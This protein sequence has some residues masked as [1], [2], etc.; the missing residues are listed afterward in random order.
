LP[1]VDS[2]DSLQRALNAP[3][4]G[5]KPSF[6][7]Q[8]LQAGAITAE[9]LKSL[10]HGHPA[11]QNNHELLKL[12]KT[13]SGGDRGRLDQ[14]YADSLDLPLVRLAQFDIDG[15]ALERVPADFSRAHELIPLSM[16]RDRLVVA[17]ANPTDIETLN[18]LH[19]ITN[20]LIEPVYAPLEEIN[21]AISQFYSPSDDDD[22]LR[23]LPTV[24]EEAEALSRQQAQKLA[25]DKPTVKLINNLILDAIN[26]R[27][28]DIHLRPEEHCVDIL[29]RIDGALNRIRTLTKPMLS[30][31]IARIK[32]IGGMNIAEH[33]LPQD[34]RA[35]V[36]SGERLIDLRISIMPSIH[37]ESAVIRI[38]DTSAGL[39][40][41]A[42]LG[43]TT[44]DA[45]TFRHIMNRSSGLYLVT[46]PTGSGKSTTLYAALQEVIKRNINVI[47]VEDPV[48]Y[49]LAGVLQIQTH[50]AIGYTF[51]RALRN[52]LRH[53]PDAIMIGEIRDEETAR[54]AVESALTGHLV[55]STLHTNS[56]ASTV[57]RLLEIGIP[58]YLLRSTLL[59][60]L[61]QRLVR[62]NCPHCLVE[63][64]VDAQMAEQ[65]RV[66]PHEVFW[67]GEGCEQCAGT[68]YRGRIAVYEQLLID[69]G[70]RDLITPDI[71]ATTIEAAA[72]QQGM[73]PLT[74]QALGLARQKITSLDEVY[75]VRLE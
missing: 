74:Q 25:S 71:S 67:R 54:I 47:T 40:S 12:L 65:L 23:T 26:R 41:V 13:I 4:E 39:R 36:K 50:S 46:G 68:G 24:S 8:L 15:H 22:V 48:E 14:L 44:K 73:V 32:I 18:L 27:A 9:K 10:L 70:L 28:S 31:A 72:T 55:L 6:Q 56:A 1:I 66:G 59:G 35:R 19:F 20:H 5:R 17:M 45:N 49:H 33:R 64:S 60:V 42:D 43:F 2:Q 51:A 69:N 29:F 16:H 37:G 61:A 11:L 34:G 52:I 58:A 21:L 30:A 57:T 53:D 63:D 7:D 38:L 75:R 3:S 62:R